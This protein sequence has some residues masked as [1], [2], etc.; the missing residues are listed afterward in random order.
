LT[1]NAPGSGAGFLLG[2]LP[3]LLAFAAGQ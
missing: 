2:A 1:S 3:L